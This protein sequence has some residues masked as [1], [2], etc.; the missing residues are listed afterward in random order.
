MQGKLLQ[1]PVVVITLN[2]IIMGVVIFILYNGTVLSGLKV[3]LHRCFD[4]LG[5]LR[6]S[7]TYKD[8]ILITFVTKFSP[9]THEEFPNYDSIYSIYNIYEYLYLEY[10]Y[11]EY[12]APIK[13]YFLCFSLLLLSSTFVH[14]VMVFSLCLKK[15]YNFSKMNRHCKNNIPL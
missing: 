9:V 3:Q 5:S 11:L 4:L 13:I 12:I 6:S 2:K 7:V 1:A 10:I 8:F 14:I 15:S